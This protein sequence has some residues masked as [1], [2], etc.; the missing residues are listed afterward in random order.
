MSSPQALLNI[1]LYEKPSYLKI[2]S[3][4]EIY[5]MRTESYDY[6]AI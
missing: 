3:N 4:K 2:P 5:K 6:N 1:M